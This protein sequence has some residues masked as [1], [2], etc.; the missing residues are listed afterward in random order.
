MWSLVGIVLAGYAL[1]VDA[2]VHANPGF[3]ALC[4]ISAHV[5]CSKVV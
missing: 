1:Y 3:V 2:Q 4:D 5:S